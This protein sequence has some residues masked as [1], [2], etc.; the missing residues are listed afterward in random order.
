[1]ERAKSFNDHGGSPFLK[2]GFCGRVMK[3]VPQIEGL[4]LMFCFP[5]DNVNRDRQRLTTSKRGCREEN[6]VTEN[7]PKMSSF[8][9]TQ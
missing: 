1:M 5:F 7:P 6:E 4:A 2:N 8:V 3:L 9:W